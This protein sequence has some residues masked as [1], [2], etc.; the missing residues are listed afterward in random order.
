MRVR[1]MYD[2]NHAR[3]GCALKSEMCRKT[4]AR[5][6]GSISVGIAEDEGFRRCGEQNADRSQLC[7]KIQKKC[8]ISARWRDVTRG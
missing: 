8:K 7:K 5:C 3:M 2:Q 1:G 4:V 6:V